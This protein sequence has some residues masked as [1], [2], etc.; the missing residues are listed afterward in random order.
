MHTLLSLIIIAM[1]SSCNS[2]DQSHYIKV[3]PEGFFTV[4]DQL[5]FSDGNRFYCGFR[6]WDH[7][8]E[9]RRT[10]EQP[11]QILV[12]TKLPEDMKFIKECNIGILT[13]HFFK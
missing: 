8:Y 5:Y 1:F 11:K 9:L 6:D 10:K 7:F 2:G 13:Q 12:Q 4:E 3:Y